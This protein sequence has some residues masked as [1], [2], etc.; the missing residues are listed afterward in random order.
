LADSAAVDTAVISALY[1]DSTL[2]GLLPDGV[3]FG[4]AP[5]SKT[6]CAVV[7]LP[8][9]LDVDQFQGTAFEEFTYMVKALVKDN[10][11]TVANQAAARIDT[12]M[13][14]LPTPTGYVLTLTRRSERIAYTEPDPNN[15]DQMWQHRGGL[16]DVMVTPA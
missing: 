14:A 16:Y 8:A 9:H 4:I 7:M 12:V 6:R 2:M 5:Q 15:P 1:A 3:Y 10:S 13:R 11:V